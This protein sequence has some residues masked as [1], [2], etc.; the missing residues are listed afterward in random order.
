MHPLLPKIRTLTF[1]HYHITG[2]ALFSIFQICT[3]G[4]ANHWNGQVLLSIALQMVSAFFLLI[5]LRQYYRNISYQTMGII[6]LIIR[7]VGASFAI[8]CIWWFTWFGIE[9]ALFGS[10]LL[11]HLSNVFNALQVVAFAFPH[12]LGWSALY[13]GIKSW[14]DWLDERNKTE[15]A[16]HAVHTAQLQRLRYQLNPHFLFNT[17][18][19][20]RALVDED[21]KRAKKM[22]TDL[23]EFLRYSLVSRNK[24]V[25][26]FKDELD[27]IRL[28]L[29]IEQQRYEDKLHVL[30]E[31]EPQT[32]LFPIPSFTVFPLIEY[33]VKCGIATCKLP[34]R[35]QVH[36]SFQH[37]TFHIVIRYSGSAMTDTNC[38]EN[39]F[40]QVQTR[41][42]TMSDYRYTLSSS[43]RDAITEIV[44]DI[45]ATNEE[46]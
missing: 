24:S 28:Y 5:L 41:L 1:W 4:I 18:N 39:G 14:H 12:N 3:N 33:A 32:E 6:P 2:W 19:A 37:A 25:V 34:L 31:I 21:T 8:T 26:L 29:S 7:I 46:P 17:L 15:K 38:T 11:Q 9:Y 43:C 20:I 10:R 22:V 36:A 40:T 13:F 44:F 42:Q 27:S 16:E 30:W 35:L 45:M 23:S